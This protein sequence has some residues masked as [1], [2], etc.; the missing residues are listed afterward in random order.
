MVVAIVVGRAVVKVV[1][2]MMVRVVV[3]VMETAMG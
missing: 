1:M 2:W 3:V